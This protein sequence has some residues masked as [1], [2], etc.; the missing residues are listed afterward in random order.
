M[1]PNITNKTL[2]VSLI[3]KMTNSNTVTFPTSHF[4]DNSQLKHGSSIFHNCAYTYAEV[5]SAPTV[6]EIQKAIIDALAYIIDSRLVHYR[7]RQAL[8][9]RVK[10]G[11]YRF[12]GRAEKHLRYVDITS[13]ILYTLEL[14][15]V[16]VS[17]KTLNLVLTTYLRNNVDQLLCYHDVDIR[18]SLKLIF[19]CIAYDFACRAINVLAA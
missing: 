19:E 7:T 14:Y 13:P 17:D 5:H 11:V 9:V 10:N 18:A 16:K 15:G 8:L 2:D 12:S 6:A 1:N 3:E 4:T